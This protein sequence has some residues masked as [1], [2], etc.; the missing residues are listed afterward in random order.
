MKQRYFLHLKCQSPEDPRNTHMS[1]GITSLLLSST[2]TGRGEGAGQQGW[3][4]RGRRPSES[5]VQKKNSR[6]ERKCR[7]SHSGP[8]SL[9][10][11]TKVQRAAQGPVPY[12]GLPGP[13]FREGSNC[14]ESAR[15]GKRRSLTV[16]KEITRGLREQERHITIGEWKPT[17][18]W[19]G[20][21]SR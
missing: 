12:Q 15:V 8:W 18:L 3:R 16:G 10:L 9:P 5:T 2:V 4:H 7:K 20:G 21:I 17:R 6:C 11:W 14:A 19:A 1:C 13:Q